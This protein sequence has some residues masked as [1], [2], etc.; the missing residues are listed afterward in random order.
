[1]KQRCPHCYTRLLEELAVHLIVSC[2]CPPDREPEPIKARVR[3]PV[4]KPVQRGETLC[5]TRSA[6]NQGC[7]CQP[8]TKAATDYI[9]KRRQDP[10][11]RQKYL[12]YLA[13]WRLR[14]AGLIP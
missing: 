14:K 8:C 12:A 6:Y 10:E 7:R 13:T 2:P 9:T 5:G 3:G 11:E 1:M 4:T